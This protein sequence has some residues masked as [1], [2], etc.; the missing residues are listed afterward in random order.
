M[1]QQLYHLGDKMTCMTVDV[2]GFQSQAVYTMNIDGVCNLPPDQH[3]FD[4]HV[5]IEIPVILHRVN[6]L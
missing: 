4:G 5:T 2:L 3:R 6:G 1:E